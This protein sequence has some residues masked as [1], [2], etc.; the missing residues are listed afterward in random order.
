MSLNFNYIYFFLHGKN[1]LE[2]KESFNA[3]IRL[4]WKKIMNLDLDNN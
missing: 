3:S 2:S 4:G 1:K